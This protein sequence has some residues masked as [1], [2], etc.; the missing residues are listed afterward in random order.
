MTNPEPVR[1]DARGRQ[2]EEWRAA[3]L[4]LAGALAKV[5]GLG[6]ARREIQ[7]LLDELLSKEGDVDGKHTADRG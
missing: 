5:A 3:R 4:H 7:A 1:R 6:L 2:R